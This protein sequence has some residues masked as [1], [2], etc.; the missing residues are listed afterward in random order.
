[1]FKA[2]CGE[3]AV[4]FLSRPVSVLYPSEYKTVLVA[5]F[6]LLNCHLKELLLFVIST[7]ENDE[8]MV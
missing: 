4:L 3:N 1:M 8:Q 7:Y 5:L 2:N 6:G